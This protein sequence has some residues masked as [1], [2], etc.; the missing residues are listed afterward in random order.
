MEGWGWQSVHDPKVL[1]KVLE[2]W[3]ASIA[4]GQPFDMDFPLRGADGVF[5]SFLTRVLPLKDSAG[6]VVRWFGTNTDISALKRAE[7]ALHRLNRMLQALT[8]S[9]RAILRAAEEAEYLQEICRIIVE[10]CGYAMVWVGFAEQDEARSVRP[11]AAAGFEAG[12][13]DTLQLSWADTERGRG[14]TGTAIRTG[15]VTLCRNMQTDPQFAPWRAEAIKRGYAS[16][17]VFPLLADGR[18]FGA[19]NVYSGE[20][21]GFND[22]EAKLLAELAGDFAY[23][24]TTLRLR[25][26]HAAAEVALRESE[27]RYRSLFEN[28]MHGF[29]HCKM[30]YDESGRPSDFIYLDVNSAFTKLTGLQNVAGR[31]VT[32]VIPGIRETHPEL[33]DIYGRVAST[34]QP[35]KFEIEF[36][37]LELWFAISVYSTVKENFVAI[38]D[39]ITERK[40]AETALFESEERY[41]N[42]IETASEGIWIGDF[43]G[44][45][46]FVNESVTKMIGYGPEELI[47]K[48]ALDFMDD[49]AR[50]IARFNLELRRQGHKNS[51]ELKF[52]RKDGS[53]LWAIVGATPLRDKNGNVVASMAMITDITERKL[54]EEKTLHQQA[55]LTSINR[56]FRE[57]LT[58]GS[59]EEL[60]RGCL[61]IAEE[62]T[63][64]KCGFIGE[65]GPD[66]LLHDTAISDPG[67]DLCT[68]KDKTGHHKPLGAFKVHG[69]F[70]RVMSDE[71]P[72]FTNDPYSHHDS[73]G[74]PDGHPRLTAFIGVPLVH[75]GKT[76]GL[77]A[78]GDREG[79]IAPRMWK[80]WNRSQPSLCRP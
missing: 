23:G 27:E 25:T 38:F 5:R 37:P 9:G 40:K 11:A 75:R 8:H 55:V 63:G 50:A 54:V 43:E 17:A 18:A 65:I 74:T 69:L 70:G 79:G 60:G 7:D 31:R 76:I 78:L 16:S 29:A 26:A 19:L 41:R 56:I 30:L 64:S 71:R 61:S 39:D 3:K 24:I 21:E 77:L 53:T 67:W 49:E 68:M 28:M 72:F 80:Q 20:T 33:F 44:R 47:G 36:K 48:T 35:E 34:G 2:R 10:D 6:L 58:A 57:A 46:S 52:I 59:E 51:Y 32:E 73:I 4:T 15:R 66:G 42:I 22:D 13:L 12:Y 45:T 62:L 1:P 14:P